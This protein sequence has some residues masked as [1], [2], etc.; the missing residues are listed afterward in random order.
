[1]EP[2]DVLHSKTQEELNG[3]ALQAESSKMTSEPATEEPKIEAVQEAETA[4]ETE[5]SEPT[6]ESNELAETTNVVEEDEILDEHE[7]E[8]VEDDNQ[9]K[10]DYSAFEGVDFVNELRQ[11]VAN[12]SIDEVSDKVD[13]L[14]VAFYKKHKLQQAEHKKAY[15]EAGGDEEQYKSEPDPYESDIRNL[16]KEFKQRK[17]EL[18]RV[19]EAEKEDN[20]KKKY[21]IIEEIKNLINGKEDFHN[22]FNE[23]K[24]LQQKWREIG[25]VPQAS[26]KDL[27]D[28][29]HHHVENFYDYIK[30]NQELRDLDL[31][32]NLEAKIEL[33]EKA[34]ALLLESSVVKAFNMLQKY[35]E[36]WREVGPVPHEKK[37]E[38]W[39][40]FKDV[41]TSINKK[42]QD[43]FENRKK[44]QKKN[45]DAK[46]AICEKID[47]ILES[48]IANHKEWDEKAAEIVEFQKLWRT[49]GF[50]PRKENNEIYDRFRAACDKFFDKKRE[51]YNKHRD[52][53]A[54]NL[55]Q[56]IE[57]CVQA[58]SLKDS[59]DWKKTTD[60]LIAIQKVWKGIG[61]VPK[62]QSDQVWKRF[63]AACDHFFNQKAQF[64]SGRDQSENEN[65]QLKLALIEEVKNFVPG[66]NEN[67]SFEKL[68][69]M[70]RRWTDIGHVPID[71]KNDVQKKFREVINKQFDQLRV[72]D[73][74]R[75][76]NRF[77]N[78]LNDMSNTNKGGGNKLRSEREKHIMKL[79]QLESDLITL[80]N[81]IGFFANSKNAEGLINDVK[82]KIANSEEQIE[83]LKDKIR[84]IDELDNNQD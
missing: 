64:F 26:M 69:E 48:T 33:C 82:R 61:P 81:N 44:S 6:S 30:I 49:I 67:E 39:E 45:L 62:K 37:E 41:T 57:L 8:G 76:L 31:K 13:Y 21:E 9:A 43:F 66:D 2:K 83:L 79:K 14:K 47:E 12:E 7:D 46:T 4:P 54:V 29:Y 77:K 40:R 3:E 56:K 59:T 51:F 84:V 60:E 74:D 55:E 15:L 50:A 42:H 28:T 5:V 68:K 36:L 63:R 19:L 23:F 35:H 24:A 70:Q 65:L 52:E 10:P 17:F 1:M 72:E 58:E 11:L 34:E 80:K 27:W 20:L 22:T 53:Q 32:R 25:L 73:R 75:N 18:S 16:L 71:Q 78:K 38:I